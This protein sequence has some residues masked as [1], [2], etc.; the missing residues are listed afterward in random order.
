MPRR[1]DGLETRQKIL[2][3]ASK[4]FAASGFKQ[5]TN[6]EISQL[7][8]VNSALISYYFGDKEK[9]YREAWEFSLEESLARYPLNGGVSP[10][11]PVVERLAGVLAATISHNMDLECYDNGILQQEIASRTGLLD[12]IHEKTVMALRETLLPLVAEYVKRDVD[13]DEVRQAVLSLVALTIVPISKIQ[14]IEKSSPYMYQ[15]SKR[16]EH[17]CCFAISALNELRRSNEQKNH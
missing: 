8:G 6:A 17:V 3:A 11:A 9:I 2:Q 14:C 16:I 1:S 13:D 12:D 5:T 7:S 4:L 15:V 10:E